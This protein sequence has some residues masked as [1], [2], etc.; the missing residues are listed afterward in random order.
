MRASDDSDED[1]AYA[2]KPKRPRRAESGA[3]RRCFG[4]VLEMFWRCF[5]EVGRKWGGRGTEIYRV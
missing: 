1:E 2:K 3:V 5:G 4:D